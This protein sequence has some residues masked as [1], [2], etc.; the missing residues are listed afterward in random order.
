MHSRIVVVDEISVSGSINYC[1][2][3]PNAVLLDI[4]EG[5]R[6]QQQRYR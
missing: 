4:C 3:Q 5:T 6:K 2:P 1:Q